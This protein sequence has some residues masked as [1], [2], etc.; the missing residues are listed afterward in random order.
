MLLLSMFMDFNKEKKWNI[1]LAEDNLA[2]AQLL[3][4]AMEE[5]GLNALTNT[6]LKHDGEG[7]IEALESNSI[8]FD[9]ILLDLNMPRVAGKQVLDYLKYD[10]PAIKPVVLVFSN[11]TYEV[12]IQ[13]CLNLGA[14]GY[15]QKPA[16]F[17]ELK[18]FC[19]VIRRS[20]EERKSIDVQYIK[21]SFPLMI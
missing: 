15:I 2:E 6:I 11:S 10:F 9:L 8:R 12:D 20:I 3:K 7:V 5:A 21:D 13:E 18:V 14:D 4:I 16:N 19:E 1:L 17:D